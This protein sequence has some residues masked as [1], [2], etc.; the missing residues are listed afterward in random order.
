MAAALVCAG[1]VAPRHAGA[2]TGTVRS[3]PSAIAGLGA[4]SQSGSLLT[5]LERTLWYFAEGSCAAGDRTTIAFLNPGSRLALVLTT[6]IRTDG[7]HVYATTDV[8]PRSRGTLDASFAAGYGDLCAAIVRSS[9]P[10][11]AERT[12]YHGSAAEEGTGAATT[13]G[14]ESTAHRW[15]LPRLPVSSKEQEQLAILNPYPFAV[16]AAVA[17]VR[18][19]RLKAPSSVSVA[20]LSVVGSKCRVPPHR[21]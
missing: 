17:L 1:V 2:L 7:R 10:I 8:A 11:V 12:V 20:P 13:A 6:V 5:G 16:Q 18:R 19:G 9:E 4:D 14:L 21:G 15:Y 3:M